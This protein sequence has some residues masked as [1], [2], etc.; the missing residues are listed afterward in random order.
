MRC[1]GGGCFE[2]VRRT[3]DPPAS[4]ELTTKPLRLR[5]GAR[6]EIW[7]VRDKTIGKVVTYRTK[8]DMTAP[9]RTTKCLPPDEVIPVKCEG[10]EALP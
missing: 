10:P 2:G 7:I 1:Q 3:V 9:T 8:D 6:I 4:V 5:T